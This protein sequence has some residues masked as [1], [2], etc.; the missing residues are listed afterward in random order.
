MG[1]PGGS[2]SKD[3]PCNAGDPGSIPGSGRCPTEEN[4]YPLLYSCLENPMDKG[5]WSATLYGVSKDRTQL[6]D[7]HLLTFHFISIKGKKKSTKKG[8][9]MLQIPEP[10]NGRV[11]PQ[12]QRTRTRRPSQLRACRTQAPAYT[13][14]SGA[15]HGDAEMLLHK[16]N[17]G[18]L[19]FTLAQLPSLDET[20]TRAPA[21]LSIALTPPLTHTLHLLASSPPQ[22]TS[23]TLFP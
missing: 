7:Y 15:S 17:H 16:A 14:T 18:R 6:S 3:S 10:V 21:K 22:L 20:P 23:Y 9:V 13:P 8:N 11:W 12:A 2:G 4:G 5:S 1:V 19:Q